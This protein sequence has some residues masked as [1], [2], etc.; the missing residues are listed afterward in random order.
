[1]AGSRPINYTVVGM[2][3]AGV[4]MTWTS[5]VLAS[6]QMDTVALPAFTSIVAVDS[7]Y[8]VHDI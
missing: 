3:G 4:T 2:L 1:M 7:T 6:T 8:D 5:E